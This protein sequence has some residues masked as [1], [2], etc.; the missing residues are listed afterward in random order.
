M[1]F[2]PMEQGETYQPLTLTP[3]D[4]SVRYTTQNAYRIGNKVYIAGE[5]TV[6]TAISSWSYNYA[7]NLPIPKSGTSPRGYFS[8][9]DTTTMSNSRF[10]IMSRIDSNGN[11]RQDWAGN[12]AA[13]RKLAFYIMYLTDD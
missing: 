4:N 8:Q 9:E 13:G 6:D 3:Q 2:E 11:L 12:V 10:G 7:T 1:A 5:C